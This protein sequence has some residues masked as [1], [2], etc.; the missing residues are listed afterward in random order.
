M[1]NVASTE[2]FPWWWWACVCVPFVLLGRVQCV[3]RGRGLLR[4]GQ[5]KLLR[6][7]ALDDDLP[8]ICHEARAAPLDGHGHPPPTPPHP[9]GP[10]CCVSCTCQW[11]AWV[12]WGG[13]WAWRCPPRRL[14]LL[15][16]SASPRAPMKLDDRDAPHTRHTH[17]TPPHPDPHLHTLSP[18][19]LT[20]TY[21]TEAS[22]AQ[23]QVAMPG[24]GSS[25]S[26]IQSA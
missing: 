11:I 21:H 7:G 12:G 19:I 10:T 24:S 25:N 15:Q 9:R 5:A 4:G 22:Q 1:E 16:Q 17:P 3:R 8:R 20:H 13:G 26:R 6:F 23:G 18:Y 14:R 2:S